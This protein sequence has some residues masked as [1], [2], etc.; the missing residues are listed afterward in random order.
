MACLT[1]ALLLPLITVAQPDTLRQELGK[2]STI[3]DIAARVACYDTLARPE[4]Q[5]TPLPKATTATAATAATAAVKAET[6]GKPNGKPEVKEENEE[7]LLSTVTSLKEV[8]PNK[9]QITLANGQVWQQID[10]THMSARL[11]DP[12]VRIKPAMMGNRWYMAV[13]KYNTQAQVKRVK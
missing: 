3:A 12:E 11:T 1:G 8:Q 5:A 13:G 2:C 7:T 4:P 10:D 6:F 9:L